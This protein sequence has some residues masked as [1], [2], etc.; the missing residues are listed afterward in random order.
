M[1]GERRN[2]YAVLVGKLERKK[3]RD[4]QKYNIK[5]NLMDID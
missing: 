2:A 4:R 1:L 5:R 3:S